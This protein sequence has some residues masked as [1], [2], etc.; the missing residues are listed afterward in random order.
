MR[1]PSLSSYGR[2]ATYTAERTARLGEQ[3][4]IS[5]ERVL[6]IRTFVASYQQSLKIQEQLSQNRIRFATRLN[7]MCDEMLGLAREGER[8]RKMVG[9]ITHHLRLS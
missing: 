7:E 6:T 9:L 1:D 2:Q 3:T 8:Q 5:I 4:L